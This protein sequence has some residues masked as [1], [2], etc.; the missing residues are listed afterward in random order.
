MPVY[1]TSASGDLLDK[2]PIYEEEVICEQPLRYPRVRGLRASTRWTD[3]V[4]RTLLWRP[5]WRSLAPL[6]ALPPIAGAAIGAAAHPPPASHYRAEASV[7][8]SGVS[9]A[10]RHATATLMAGMAEL[11]GV[12]D[13]A[14]SSTLRDGTRVTSRIYASGMLTFEVSS[15]TQP[16]A[17]VVANALAQQVTSLGEITV[18]RADHHTEIAVGNFDLGFGSWT[19]PSQFDLKAHRLSIEPRGRLGHTSLKVECTTGPGCGATSL[20]TYPFRVGV[21]YT[22]TALVRDQPG[23]LASPEVHMLFGSNDADVVTGK[24][25][26]AGRKWRELSVSWSPKAQS[27]DTVE[28]GVQSFDKSATFLLSE[29][30]MTDPTGLLNSPESSTL[31]PAQR[32]LAIKEAATAAIVPARAIGQATGSTLK[33]ALIGLAIGTLMAIAAVAGGCVAGSRRREHQS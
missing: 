32:A 20:L 30:I 15:Q 10:Q 14:V 23:S 33:W 9:P 24:G 27:T 12:V 17:L 18:D 22:A 21:T 1:S 11:P 3:L 19:G 25:I 7:I 16:I 4:H 28:I 13:A 6:L 26:R 29:V 31:T 5:R 2:L 8:P